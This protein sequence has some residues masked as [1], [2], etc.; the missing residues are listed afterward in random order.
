[1]QLQEIGQ[2]GLVLT[3][4]P[5]EEWITN[6][7]ICFAHNNTYLVDTYCGPDVMMAVRG[8]IAERA[9][10]KPIIVVNTHF[11]W[12]HIWGNCCFPEETILAHELCRSLADKHWDFQ[13]RQNHQF[14]LGKVAKHLPTHLIRDHWSNLHDSVEIFHSPG[15]TPDS[16]SFLDKKD[17]VLFV[18]DNVEYPLPY[19]ESPDLDQYILTLRN[20]LDMDYRFMVSSHSE[21]TD[22]DLILSNI[23]YLEKLKSGTQQYFIDPYAAK[24]HDL[25]LKFLQQPQV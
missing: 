12:D 24:I 19:V 5:M 7:Y 23:S 15:H 3:F 1:M 8:V 25:N 10:D 20:Y 22:D 16:I 9:G 4:E 21:F 18:G 14:Q 17:G 13:V 11:H 2:R 6:I